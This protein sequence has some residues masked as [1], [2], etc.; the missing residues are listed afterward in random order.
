MRPVLE[1]KF[2]VYG[3]KDGTIYKN[4]NLKKGRESCITLINPIQVVDLCRSVWAT[5][6]LETMSWGLALMAI[7]CLALVASVIVKSRHFP[8]REIIYFGLAGLCFSCGDYVLRRNMVRSAFHYNFHPFLTPPFPSSV[9][10]C[11]CGT[12]RVWLF[13]GAHLRSFLDLVLPQDFAATHRHGPQPPPKPP[14]DDHI[15][16]S[17]RSCSRRGA[18]F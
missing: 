5:F 7:S 13:S 11:T 12:A 17:V 18:V 3:G 1:S 8:F 15:F 9:V 10:S 2:N 16:S 4:K 6:D 14:N